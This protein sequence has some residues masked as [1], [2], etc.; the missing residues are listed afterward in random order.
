MPF[1]HALFACPLKGI[2]ILPIQHKRR[3][4]AAMADARGDKGAVQPATRHHGRPRGKEVRA[5]LENS[6]LFGGGLPAGLVDVG[7]LPRVKAGVLKH[8]SARRRA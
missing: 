5:V 6:G 7:E 3:P 1:S 2:R 4:V 8:N